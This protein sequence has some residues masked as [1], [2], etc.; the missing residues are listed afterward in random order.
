MPGVS[1]GR[2]YPLR[3]SLRFFEL[4]LLPESLWLRGCSREDHLLLVQALPGHLFPG[5]TSSFPGTLRPWNRD[6]SD[7]V[8]G[9]D[10]K[11]TA[12]NETRVG[13]R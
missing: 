6:L 7:S 10:W 9:G 12:L 3:F 4:S 1:D 13:G 2:R 5:N 8:C 11:D